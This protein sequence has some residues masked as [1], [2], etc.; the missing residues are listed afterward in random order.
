MRHR[1]KLRATFGK[2]PV[3][4][5]S[6]LVDDTGPGVGSF[7]AHVIYKTDVGQRITSGGV[8]SIKVKATTE[9][10]INVGDVVKYVNICLEACP[11]GADPTILNDNCAWLEWAVVW[12][13]EATTLIVPT[14]ANIGVLNLGVICSHVFRQNCL[15][16]GC[17]PIGTRQAMSQDIKIKLP[18]KCVKILMGSRLTVI[19]YVRTSKS[20]DTRTDSHRLIASSMFKC[21]S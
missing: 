14:V 3:K 17:F 20:T 9:E 15:M 6:T 16:T 19:C 11:R 18:Q 21:Y 12:Q 10:E 4:H 2:E 7:F 5:S 1:K 13:Q 8:Q